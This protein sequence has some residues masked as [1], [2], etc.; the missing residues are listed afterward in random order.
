MSTEALASFTLSVAEL[1]ML[2]AVLFFLLLKYF[3]N[4]CAEWLSKMSSPSS[5]SI[6][7]KSEKMLEQ[8]DRNVAEK[9]ALKKGVD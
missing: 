9:N 8:M 5:G 1:L 3:P 2:L 6:K 4:Y 7:R